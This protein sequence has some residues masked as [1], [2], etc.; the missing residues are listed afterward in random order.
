[1]MFMTYR[2]FMYNEEHT[3]KVEHNTLRRY[4]GSTTQNPKVEP[5]GKT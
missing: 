4:P 1:M 2:C 3:R 5:Y